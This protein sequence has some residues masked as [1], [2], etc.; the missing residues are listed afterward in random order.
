MNNFRDECIDEKIVYN[1]RRALRL[2]KKM[3]LR[4]KTHYKRSIGKNVVFLIRGFEHCFEPQCNKENLMIRRVLLKAGLLIV[5]SF[6]LNACKNVTAPP[7]TI[8]PPGETPAAQVPTPV[9]Q[10]TSLPAPTEPSEPAAEPRRT[11]GERI[12]TVAFNQEF[13]QLNPLYAQALSSLIVQEIWNCRAWNFD[14]QNN[15]QPVL[16]Q[17]IPSAQNGGI[18]PDGRE[19][20]LKLRPGIVWSD[21]QPITSQDFVFTYQMI[22][23]PANAV[24]DITPYDLVENVTAPDQQTVVVRFREPNASWLHTLWE[25]LMPAHVLEPV[26][27]ASGT[28]Q[29]AEWNRTPSVS[30]GPYVYESWETGEA[31]TFKTNENNWRDFPVLGKIIVKFY[32]D[33]ATKAQGIISGE[34]D[35]AIFLIDGATQVPLL[36]DAGMQILPVDAGYK[37]GMFFFLDPTAGN[38]ALQDVRVRQAIAMAIDRNAIIQSIY[39]SAVTPAVSYW[40]NT[41]YIDPSLQPW[42]F[43]AE[44]AKSLLDEAGWVDSNGNGARDKDGVELSLTYGT[45]TSTVR[46]AVQSA[47]QQQLQAVGVLVELSNYDPTTFF[48]GVDQGGPA[49]SGQLDIFEYSVRTT[50][51]PDPGTNDFNCDAIPSADNTQGTNWAYLCDQEL[52]DL[53]ELQATQI[54]LTQRQQTFHSISKI[55]Y[56]KVYFIGL[57]TDPDYWSANP[58]LLNVKL[59]PITPF[60]NVAEWDIK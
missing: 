32:P 58:R 24:P 40:D 16:V 57:W 12:A 48:G 14:V 3:S 23:N 20:T 38:P 41:P 50:N 30:C 53:L 4:T 22:T 54:D 31:V 36:R 55:I 47:I 46:Q 37:E 33:D 5:L 10:V 17:E 56:D 51:Y 45:T 39:S 15:P 43:D 21:G 28:I 2:I 52:D 60:F 9:A 19:I 18:S 25:V 44:K 6:S 49:A 8:P 42:Q 59:S 7:A 1:G 27:A 26:F 11:V 35:L 13:D 34:S 29:N